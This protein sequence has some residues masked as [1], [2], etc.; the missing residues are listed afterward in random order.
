MSAQIV[1]QS[2]FLW[3]ADFPFFRYG[4][5]WRDKKFGKQLTIWFSVSSTDNSTKLAFVGVLRLKLGNLFLGTLPISWQVIIWEAP[6]TEVDSFLDGTYKPSLEY[7]RK[8]FFLQCSAPIGDIEGTASDPPTLTRGF[9]LL[10]R[11]LIWEIDGC[12]F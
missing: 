5:G 1:D 8:V 11:T 12:P 4:I 9:G 2:P 3:L 7:D 10:R 6:I